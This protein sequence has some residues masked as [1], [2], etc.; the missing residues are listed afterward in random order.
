MKPLIRKRLRP[1]IVRQRHRLGRLPQLR[2]PG[3]S[4]LRRRRMPALHHRGQIPRTLVLALPQQ[5]LAQRLRELRGEHIAAGSAGG[6]GALLGL[7]V[8]VGGRHDDRFRVRGLA[9]QGEVR[10]RFRGRGEGRTIRRRGAGAPE[11][12]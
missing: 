5:V 1:I 3:I 12:R 2:R 11:S 10:S 9:R 4:L 8:S 7:G 6:E